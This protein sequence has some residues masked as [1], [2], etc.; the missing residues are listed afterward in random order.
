MSE[1]MKASAALE[2]ASRVGRGT[3]RD[4]AARRHDVDPEMQEEFLGC[5]I[6]GLEE[7][8]LGMAPKEGDDLS[9]IVNVA[10]EA[11]VDEASRWARASSVEMGC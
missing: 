1:V 4:Y 3:G 9:K 8:I 10:I 5:C 2:I 11:F 7:T 6:V